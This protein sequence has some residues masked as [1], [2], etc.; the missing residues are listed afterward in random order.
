MLFNVSKEKILTLYL[1]ILIID[2]TLFPRFYY[3]TP[4]FFILLPFV[5]IIFGGYKNSDL[6]GYILLFYIISVSVLWSGFN[7]KE[8]F[9]ENF[10]RG[11]Q[12]LLILL[13]VMFEFRKINYALLSKY[14]CIFV[15]F[16]YFIIFFLMYLF[17]FSPDLYSSIVIWVYPEAVS[18]LDINL[19]NKRFAF[20]FTDP[21]S[22][23]Y[24]MVIILAFLLSLRLPIS[25]HLFFLVC[26]LAVVM[27]TQ[28]RGGLLAYSSVFLIYYIL[29]VRCFSLKIYFFLAATTITLLIFNFH[30]EII[31]VFLES[32]SDR[33]EIESSKEN[34][35]GGSRKESWEYFFRNI[36]INPF[37]GSGYSLEQEGELYR[38]HSDFIRFN[39]SYGII[40]YFVFFYI[41]RAATIRCA[42]LLT[43]FIVPFLFNTVID[44][45]RL[46]GI[47]VIFFSIIKN[48][49][50]SECFNNKRMVDVCE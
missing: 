9:E 3:S 37:F 36:N 28:S 26:T 47:F 21:N 11:A 23:A 6:I 45:Y 35:F 29:L 27:A 12:F 19:D 1:F 14:I 32:L 40:I 8:Y 30:G 18:M 7:S 24:M 42:M 38:P 43:A 4:V 22:L 49:N 16:L 39:L 50:D 10:K 20:H 31:S 33:A 41:F 44:D 17:Y 48:Y 13:L 15:P 46:F 25:Q 5:I 2:L 34:G